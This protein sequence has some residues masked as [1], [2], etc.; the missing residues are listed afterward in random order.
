MILQKRA[1]ASIQQTDYQLR[2]DSYKSFIPLYFF[3]FVQ[4]RTL[5]VYKIK[6]FKNIEELCL[7]NKEILSICGISIQVQ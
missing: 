3:R 4:L 6:V 2:L 7:G 5:R 1:R